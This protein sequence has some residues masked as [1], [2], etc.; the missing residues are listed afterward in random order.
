MSYLSCK[1]SMHTFSHQ[2]CELRYVS[3]I[4]FK[5]MRD[6]CCIN[7]KFETQNYQCVLM[8]LHINTISSSTSNLKT[9]Q[10]NCARSTNIMQSCLE[11]A[12]SNE[13]DLVLVQEP[14]TRNQKT[15]SHSN[16]TCIISQIL[17]KRARVCVFVS[18]TNYKLSCTYRVDFVNDSD[19]QIL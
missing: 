2:M 10:H 18:R 9:M 17:N 6:D 15:V 13:N 5:Q 11:Y 4:R 12:K 1:F 7:L 8:S 3:S 16:F 19:C 14:W